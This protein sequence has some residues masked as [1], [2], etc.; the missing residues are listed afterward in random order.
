MDAG[1]YGCGSGYGCEYG[2][3]GVVTDADVGV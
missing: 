3:W 1:T 2:H